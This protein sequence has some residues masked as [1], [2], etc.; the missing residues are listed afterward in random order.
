MKNLKYILIGTFCMGMFSCTNLDEEIK[1]DYTEDFDPANQGVGVKNNVNKPTPNDGLTS[2]FN[3]LFDGTATN[4][5]FFNV[6]ELSSDEAVIAQKG[7]DW[8]DGGDFI[9]IHKHNFTPLTVS[10]ADAWDNAYGGIVECNRLLASSPTPPF[11]AQHIAQLRALRAFFYWRLLDLFGNVPIT[12][13]TGAGGSVP[14]STRA[15]VYAFVETELLAVRPDLPSGKAD[16]GRISQPGVNAL[17]SRLY[18]NALVYKGVAE[19]QKAI[20]AADL[21]INSGLYN[22]SADYAKV[23]APDNVENVEHIFIVPYDEATGQGMTF[24]QMTLH[25]PSQL[26]YKLK[27]QP[28]NGFATLETFYNS[29]EAA[30]KRRAANFISGPQLDVDGNPI[31]DLAFD[32]ADPDGPAINYTPFINELFP[33]SSRQGG[34]RLGKFAFKIG[35]GNNMDNDFPVLRY[36][37]V[38]LNKAEALC[39]LN[40]YGD[41]TALTLVNQLRTRA[42]VGTI[43]PLDAD[44]ML[45]E[46]GRELFME[47][48][49][50]TD[51]IRFGKWGAAWWEKPAHSNVNFNIFAIPKRQMDATNTSANPLVQNPGY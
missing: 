39:R 34:A 43:A 18:L 42:G 5:G 30:D 24:A 29:Y 19:Y 11:T 20:D 50:R 26:T 35:Q 9:N 7:G 22:L 14:Q 40:G 2:A 17:L 21:V 33:N 38:L 27:E 28:W 51:L 47:C 13:T 44:K 16:Y 8:Y 1:G 45:A 12:T 41:A 31:L 49:R 4:G 10:T 15:Q 36:G 32:P 48:L 25:Y 37:E 23:F 46:R 3:K 6:Q